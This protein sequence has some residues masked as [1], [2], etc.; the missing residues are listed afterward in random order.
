MWP[1]SIPCSTG[2]RSGAGSAGAGLRSPASVAAGFTGSPLPASG[3]SK[4]SERP[5][6]PLSRPSTASPVSAM[7][8]W[9]TELRARLEGLRLPPEREAEII[10]ELSQHLDDAVDELIGRGLPAQEARRRALRELD[11]TDALANALRSVE[12]S[13]SVHHTVAGGGGSGFFS[14]LAQDVRYAIRVLRE[15]PGFSLIA[16]LTLALGIGA[17]TTLFG[18]L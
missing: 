12:A 13:V 5:G 18:L 7:P 8:D 10:E 2:W 6:P 16:I 14:N 11:Q 17:T 3:C 15:R 1:R 4:A 9:T